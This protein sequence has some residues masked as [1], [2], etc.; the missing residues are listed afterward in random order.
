MQCI[1]RTMPGR[2]IDRIFRFMST[3]QALFP[4]ASM[5]RMLCVSTAGYYAWRDRPA[6]AHVQAD[7]ALLKQVRTVYANSR[8]IYGAPRIHAQLRAEGAK[9]GRKR[10]ARLMREAGLVGACHRQG[11]PTTTQ[12]NKEARPAP[13]LVDRDFTAQTHA[14]VYYIYYIPAWF[15]FDGF[16]VTDGRAEAAGR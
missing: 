8:Q 15:I 6:S 3:N 12:R 5:A 7:A 16:W 13:D 11:G 9:H 14:S 10:I 1:H 2:H 4:I